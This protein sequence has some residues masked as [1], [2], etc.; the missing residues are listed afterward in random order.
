MVLRHTT[1]EYSCEVTCRSGAASW[2]DGSDVNFT[3]WDEGEPDGDGTCTGLNSV[4]G[5]WFTAPCALQQ[6]FICKTAAGENQPVASLS[7]ESD[8]NLNEA[9]ILVS[10]FLLQRKTLWA[11][12]TS[13]KFSSFRVSS[14]FWWFLSFTCGRSTARLGGSPRRAALNS[15]GRSR[16][17]PMIR[18]TADTTSSP[19]T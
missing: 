19:S 2:S 16:P 11:W 7:F 3:I 10:S 5:R 1:P 17:R 15:L 12:P 4:T 18:S 9:P 8:A 14:C 13:G 6:G